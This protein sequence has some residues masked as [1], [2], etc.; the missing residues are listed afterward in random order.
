MTVI[1]KNA[2]RVSK[3]QGRPWSSEGWKRWEKGA[4]WLFKNS[5]IGFLG[6]HGVSQKSGINIHNIMISGAF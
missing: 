1:G 6:R 3:F 2:H 4:L 5:R